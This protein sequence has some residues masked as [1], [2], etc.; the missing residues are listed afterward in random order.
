[1]KPDYETLITQ[2]IL[3]PSVKRKAKC[4]ILFSKLKARL[5]LYS[6]NATT[7]RQLKSLSL[8]QLQDVGVTPEQAQR[9]SAKYFWEK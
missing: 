3:L 2:T 9:E 6:R 4:P 7:R 5:T 1:M 8:D